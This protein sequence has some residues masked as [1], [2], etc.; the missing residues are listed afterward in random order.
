MCSLKETK[1]RYRL[2]GIGSWVESGMGQDKTATM[3][4]KW[5]SR[6]TAVK[7]P[8]GPE[9]FLFCWT[10]STWVGLLALFLN[11]D[12][13]SHLPLRFMDGKGPILQLRFLCS[14]NGTWDVETNGSCYGSSSFHL[15]DARSLACVSSL[16]RQW[17]K[18]CLTCEYSWQ[19]PRFT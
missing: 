16:F 13:G 10:C 12:L 19:R 5:E 4:A 18:C 6:P 7:C 8:D 11:T 14:D 17:P 2:K 3:G 1:E 9:L 15:W